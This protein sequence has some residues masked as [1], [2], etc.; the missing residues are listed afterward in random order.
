MRQGWKA[1]QERQAERAAPAQPDGVELCADVLGADVPVADVVGG[2]VLVWGP[3]LSV[4]GRAV[5]MGWRLPFTV[6]VTVA[7][8]PRRMSTASG[9]VQLIVAPAGRVPM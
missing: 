5:L 8:F 3:K 7:G 6:R 9:S 4:T 1:G 2:D